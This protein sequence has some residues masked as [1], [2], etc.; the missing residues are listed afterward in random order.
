MMKKKASVAP[1][2]SLPLCRLSMSR[3]ANGREETA[4]IWKKV[5]ASPAS[6]SPPFISFMM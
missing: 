3:P 1:R 2:S 5:M 6:S 4:P